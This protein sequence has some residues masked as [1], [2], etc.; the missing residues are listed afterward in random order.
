M[1]KETDKEYKHNKQIHKKEIKY[2][3]I[4]IFLFF[5]DPQLV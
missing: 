5:A 1:N 4:T 2:L 3:K